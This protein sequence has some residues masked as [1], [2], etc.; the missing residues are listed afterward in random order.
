MYQ[1]PN[2]GPKRITTVLHPILL[3]RKSVTIGPQATHHHF[4]VLRFPFWPWICFL[5]PNF[6]PNQDAIRLNPVTDVSFE[7]TWITRERGNYEVQHMHFMHPLFNSDETEMYM[8]LTRLHRI[9]IIILSMIMTTTRTLVAC[10]S[11]SAWFG[12]T[13]CISECTDVHPGTTHQ[14]DG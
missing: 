10:L 13:K 5:F 7:H 12:R 11:P 4:V 3:C 2:L 14:T 9:S 1:T 6:F 8:Y